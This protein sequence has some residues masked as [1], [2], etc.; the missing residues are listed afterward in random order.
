MS[1]PSMRFI[2]AA[3]LSDEPEPPIDPAGAA[4]VE[5]FDIWNEVEAD[6]ILT[7]LAIRGFKIVAI[8]GS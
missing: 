3:V 7:H 6:R 8:G 4:L 5:Y 1:L 2:G